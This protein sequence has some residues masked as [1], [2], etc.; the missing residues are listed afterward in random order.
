MLVRAILIPW[1]ML[2]SLGVGA[3]EDFSWLLEPG[4]QPLAFP[5]LDPCQSRSDA[6]RSLDGFA[7]GL[8]HLLHQGHE[9]FALQRQLGIDAVAVL[10]SSDGAMA[11]QIC[12]F[13][14]AQ[15]QLPQLL[16]DAAAANRSNSECLDQNVFLTRLTVLYVLETLTRF[17]DGICDA[18]SCV[19]VTFGGP[20][21]IP[22]CAPPSA[23]R[24]ITASIALDLSVDDQCGVSE[25]ERWMER[26]RVHAN[27][28]LGLLAQDVD[29]LIPALVNIASNAITAI[30]VQLFESDINFGFGSSSERSKGAGSGVNP[31]LAELA[32]T[33]E[34]G[35]QQQAVYENQALA[36]FIEEALASETTIHILLLPP[37]A[38]GM[39]V[40]VRELVA[41]RLT[42]VASTGT[43]VARARARFRAGDQ[44][45]NQAQ[46][47]AAY[48]AYGDAYRTLQELPIQM[49]T[50]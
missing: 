50:N 39:L 38:G 3:Q 25:H 9:D 40:D 14:I 16:A 21:C 13:L 1:L 29:T 48:V 10:R 35:I 6:R 43:S 33:I 4:V 17:L 2:T 11:Q 47:G 5:L 7:D 28:Q 49:G 45:F 15:P 24:F 31:Q 41:E 8:E 34:A 12:A 32:E 37:S 30:T 22:A 20:V 23:L 26:A 36:Q 42:A 46:F 44:A 19:P 18:A 27:Q